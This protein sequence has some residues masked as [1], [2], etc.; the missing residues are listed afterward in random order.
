M[1][2]SI[3][4]IFKIKIQSDIFQIKLPMQVMFVLPFQF[5]VDQALFAILAPKAFFFFLSSTI[6]L[7]R[8]GLV[9]FLLRVSNLNDV[10]L[11]FFLLLISIL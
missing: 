2:I 6:F 9:F 7:Q 3:F 11:F 10:L 8:R 1:C 5:D 4:L